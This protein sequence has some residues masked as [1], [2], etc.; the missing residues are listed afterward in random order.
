M[1]VISFARKISTGFEK[2][3]DLIWVLVS[4]LHF[5]R[6]SGISFWYHSKQTYW[7]LVQ[8]WTGR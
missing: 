6:K 8:L 2:I 7:Y 3:K 5:E 1:F 4:V